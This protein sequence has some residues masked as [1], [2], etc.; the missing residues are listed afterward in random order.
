MK[1]KS[2][3]LLGFKCFNKGLVNNYNKSFRINEIYHINNKINYGINGNGFHMCTNLEDTLRYYDTFNKNVRYPFGYGLSY[4]K[5]EYNNFN[6][7][8]DN[9]LFKIKFNVKNVGSFKAKDTVMLFLEAPKTIGEKKSLIGYV[10]T[11][12]LEIGEKEEVYISFDLFDFS[13]T[14][15]DKRMLKKGVYIINYGSDV[16]NYKP[17][18]KF[19]L[20]EDFILYNIKDPIDSYKSELE[21]ESSP[22]DI[23]IEEIKI[24]L[25]Y[26]KESHYLNNN[27][28]ILNGFSLRDR[29]N[30]CVGSGLLPKPNF[31]VVQGCAGY[32]TPYVKNIPALAMADGPSGIR[33]SPKVK[34]KINGKTKAIIPSMGVY[35]YLPKFIKMF[36]YTKD[37]G[38]NIGYQKATS[39]PAGISLAATFNNDLIKE[40][41]IAISKE[42][43]SLGISYYLAPAV[44]IIKNPIGGRSF[45]YYSEDPYLAGMVSS[46]II[47]GIEDSKGQ[48]AVLKHYACNNLEF[49]RNKIS[50][51]VS[52]N[53][54]K[55]IYLKPFELAI[56]YSKVSAIMS[57]YN[58]INGE[59]VCNNSKLLNDIL[60]L[61]YGFNGLIMT[62]WLSTSNKF[63]SN[64]KAIKSGNDLIMPG[65]KKAFNEILRAY[66]KK[67]ITA[68][69][70]NRAASNVLRSIYKT[71]IY[72]KYK[73]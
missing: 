24:N 8:V 62:D 4:S 68:E 61:E 50:A 19:K 16:S 27:F 11:K 39:F 14:D 60:R 9:S 10:K 22:I 56:K 21:K 65:S 59:Y 12:E 2:K 1:N 67:R 43:N 35:N 31:V 37:N 6:Y 54:L 28:D 48:F 73:N 64:I 34:I 33:I 13:Y 18:Y 40:V 57:S 7:E 44:N 46:S 17:I 55:D 45:E 52:Y 63:A 53:A 42:L 23:D 20:E 47:N 32:T 30:L 15:I 25:N 49:M 38:K 36:R 5:F 66:K 69:E 58:K 26:K 70:L 71:S 51:N 72:K 29:I 3:I 41:G